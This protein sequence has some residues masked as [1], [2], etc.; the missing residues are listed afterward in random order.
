MNEQGNAAEIPHQFKEVESPQEFCL[1][2]DVVL[3]GI[4]ERAAIDAVENDIGPRYS[5]ESMKVNVIAVVIGGIVRKIGDVLAHGIGCA[6]VDLV[7]LVMRI[8]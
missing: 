7:I 8:I 5:F 6:A 4:G 1:S 2:N 3:C